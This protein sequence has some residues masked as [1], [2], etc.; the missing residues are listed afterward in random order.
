MANTYLWAGDYEKA[1]QQFQSTIELD[2]RFPMA[3]FF[4]AN[5]LAETGKYEQGIEEM[6]KGEGLAGASPGQAATEAAEFRS[7]FQTGGPKGYWQK[8]LE[9]TLKQLRE[10][11]A[12]YFP[13][14]GVS[15]RMQKWAITRKRWSG[16][17]SHMR[18]GTVTSLS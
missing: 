4:Y 14:L 2:P 9:A 12:Q 11:E 10:T 8:N 1:A 17:T 15:P 3:H 6:Q 16:L 18:K 13:A 7:A 5:L